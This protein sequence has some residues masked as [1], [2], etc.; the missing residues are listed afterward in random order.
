MKDEKSK[1]EEGVNVKGWFVR[2]K[3]ISYFLIGALL[4]FRICLDLC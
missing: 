2:E 3:Y 1:N 4:H